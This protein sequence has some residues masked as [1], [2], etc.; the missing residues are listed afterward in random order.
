[1]TMLFSNGPLI[2]ITSLKTSLRG[3]GYHPKFFFSIDYRLTTKYDQLKKT[4]STI[5]I[6]VKIQNMFKP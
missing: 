1:M 2:A 6:R 5:K 4:S 3:F